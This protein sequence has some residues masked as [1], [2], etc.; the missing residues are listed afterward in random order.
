M[1]VRSRSRCSS[2]ESLARASV[3]SAT[4]SASSASAC[5]RIA[6]PS[7]SWAGRLVDERAHQIGE[8][9]AEL[10]Q[11]AR[12]ALRNCGHCGLPR[13][14]PSISSVR[15]SDARSRGVARRNRTFCAMRSRSNMPRENF[16]QRDAAARAR[17]SNAATHL[18]TH[19]DR[20]RVDQRREDPARQ[21]ARAHRRRTEVERRE[22][23]RAWDFGLARAS[24]RG[25]CASRDRA[26]KNSWRR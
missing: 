17:A 4:H 8:Q 23:R 16:A 13:S 19:R 21:H 10:V 5:G 9:V 7:P 15:R 20:R 1:P 11:R 26:T 25:V 6:P 24:A 2:S 14:G 18:L 22:Q 12:A 3:R